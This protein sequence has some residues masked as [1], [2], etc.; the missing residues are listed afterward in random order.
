[1]ALKD[2]KIG[3]IGQGWLGKNYADDFEER[4]FPVVRY[5]L[6]EPYRANKDKIASCD[7]VFV[8]VPTPTTPQGFDGS[9]VSKVVPLVGEGKIAVVR[10]T[11]RPGFTK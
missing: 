10:S 11:L 2:L 3:F 7:I 5:S 6:E 4:G 1:M 8:A 9:L